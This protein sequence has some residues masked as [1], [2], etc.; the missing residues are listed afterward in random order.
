MQIHKLWHNALLIHMFI[1]CVH[2]SVIVLTEP[3]RFIMYIAGSCEL[4]LVSNLLDFISSTLNARFLAV[5][6]ASLAACCW[7]VVPAAWNIRWVVVD[8]TAYGARCHAVVLSVLNVFE[9]WHCPY[10]QVY[11]C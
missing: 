4:C 11:A 8:T 3:N 10:C 9:Y 1:K 6:P 7:S 5:G 2:G